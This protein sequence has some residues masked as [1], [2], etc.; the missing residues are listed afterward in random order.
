MKE[1]YDDDED[2]EE[3]NGNP[4]IIIDRSGSVEPSLDNLEHA[5]SLLKMDKRPLFK[6]PTIIVKEEEFDPDADVSKMTLPQQLAW[7]KKKIE[8]LTKQKLSERL[9]GSIVFDPNADLSQMTES[10][11]A[12][13]KRQKVKLS[14]NE[15]R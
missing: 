11:K 14:Y 6:K 5:K 3:S 10:E 15:K 9:E 2:E 7:N 8:F 1:N 12:S 13:W 4:A